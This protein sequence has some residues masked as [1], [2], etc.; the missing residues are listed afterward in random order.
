MVSTA[1]W[2]VLYNEALLSE[3]ENRLTTNARAVEAIL[4]RFKVLH[5][6]MLE[7]AGR[8]REQRSLLR[9][10]SDLRVLR[11]SAV[12]SLLFSPL[13]FSARRRMIAR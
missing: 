10:L 9:A 13:L 3:P 5:F 6:D 1:F 7:T 8:V 4:E 2:E 12:N 11:V